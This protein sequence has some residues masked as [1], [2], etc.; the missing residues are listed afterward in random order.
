MIFEKKQKKTKTKCVLKGID[1]ID[2]L[3]NLHLAVSLPLAPDCTQTK[4]TTIQATGVLFPL[5]L[6]NDNTFLKIKPLIMEQLQH[7]A[8]HQETELINLRLDGHEPH[9]NV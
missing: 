2:I 8:I 6:V 9:E 4:S 3:A 1:Y 5:C 7:G